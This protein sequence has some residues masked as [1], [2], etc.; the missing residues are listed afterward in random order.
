M[1]SNIL[2]AIYFYFLMP[3]ILILRVVFVNDESTAV[4]KAKQIFQQPYH[5]KKMHVII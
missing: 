4:S 5:I 3:K 2:N 1:K